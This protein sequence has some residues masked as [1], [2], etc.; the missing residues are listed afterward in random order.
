MVPTFAAAGMAAGTIVK[1]SLVRFT[2]GTFN[3][4][5]DTFVNVTSA[6]TGAFTYASGNKVLVI[7]ESNFYVYS[8]GE[9][10]GGTLQLATNA[11]D[12]TGLIANTSVTNYIAVSAD[13][14]AHMRT[15]STIYYLDDA[16]AD[17][18]KTYYMQMRR[19]WGAS[20]QYIRDESS[21]LLL[22]I[23]A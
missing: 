12:A 2:A 7:W 16:P 4:T 1:V 17:T 9:D 18:S 20:A 15:S 13:A 14:Q 10:S 5:S 6:N 22:E 11:S 3:T 19:G 23:K 21:V 8:G